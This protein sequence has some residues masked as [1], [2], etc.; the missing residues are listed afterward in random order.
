[1]TRAT[2]STSAGAQRHRD[3]KAMSA[4]L[5]NGLNHPTRRM[6]LRKLS[7]NGAEESPSQMAKFDQWA[8][9]T[10]SHHARTLCDIGV[11]R[12]TR[13]SGKEGWEQRFYASNVAGNVLVQTILSETEDE[14]TKLLQASGRPAAKRL[15]RPADGMRHP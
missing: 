3:G 10:V 12:L 7:A 5:I 8:L 11:L 6:I 9:P 1:M 13:S 4:A 2:R 14:D 15:R